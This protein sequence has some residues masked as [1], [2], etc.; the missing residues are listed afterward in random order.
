MITIIPKWII[1]YLWF[2]TITTIVFTIVGYLMPDIYTSTGHNLGEGSD[3]LNMYLSRNIAIIALY[4]FALFYKRIIVFK[5]VFVLRGVIDVLELYKDVSAENFLEIPFI[6][7]L[8]IIDI[9]ALFT[10]YKLKK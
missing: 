2:I 8:L 5:A 1:V 10:L 7:I 4:L 9:Y 3:L 6:L